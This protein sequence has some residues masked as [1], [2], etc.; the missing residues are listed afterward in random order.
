MLTCKNVC[1]SAT[2]FL[3]GPT[4]FRERLSLRFH[5]LICAKCRQ[6]MEQFKMTIGVSSEIAEVAAPTDEEIEDLV[7]QL[8]AAAPKQP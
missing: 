4:T 3:E 1:D 2:A 5:L 7:R 8:S 6:F